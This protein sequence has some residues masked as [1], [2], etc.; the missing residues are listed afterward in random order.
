MAKIG[1]YYL[2]SLPGP[3]AETRVQGTADPNA[4]GAGVGQAMGNVGNAISSAGEAVFKNDLIQQEK[5]RKMN[6]LNAETN[7]ETEITNL[8]YGQEGLLHLQ[9]ENALPKVATK[10]TAAVPGVGQRVTDALAGIRKKYLDGFADDQEKMVFSQMFDDRAR[11]YTRAAM[12]HEV[13]QGDIAFQQS[14]EASR[15]S[16]ANLFATLAEKGD[17]PGA[18]TALNTGMGTFNSTGKTLGIPAE[19]L[20]QD[21]DAYA[22]STIA[23]TIIAQAKAKNIDLA[24]RM[25]DY[26]K[27]DLDVN[28]KALVEGELKPIIEQDE[29]L[30]FIET[31][32]KNDPSL[33]NPD[34]SINMDKALAKTTS[35][36]GPGVT[37][38]VNVPG[39]GQVSFEQLKG[40]VARNESGGNYDAHNDDSG[41]HGKYQFMPGTWS[42]IMSD[43]PMTPENQELAF[44]K[45]YKPIYDEYGAAGVLVAVYAGDSNAERY[46]KGENLIGD[47][48]QPYSADAPQ[49][50]YPSV[51]QY[52]I[53]ALGN[54]GLQGGATTQTVAAYDDPVR[55]AKLENL[56]RATV[57]DS[58]R[59][60]SQ[61]LGLE[62][63]RVKN[64]LAN[65]T[66]S[67]EQ[68]ETINS[69]SLPDSMKKDWSDKITAA[70]QSNLSKSANGALEVLKASGG[71]T[72]DAVQ[73]MKNQLG[74]TEYVSWLAKATS[75]QKTDAE[76][77]NDNA[78]TQWHSWVKS[79]LF[80]GK[81]NQ[82]NEYIADLKAFLDNE[83]ANGG[84]RTVKARQYIDNQKKD[85][86]YILGYRA[87]NAEGFNQ[88]DQFFP[89]DEGQTPISSLILKA[90]PN[91]DADGWVKMLNQFSSMVQEGDPDAT[92]AWNLIVDNGLPFTEETFWGIR[93]E[94]ARANNRI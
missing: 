51:R 20:K 10:D 88:I 4:F 58:V 49:G 27:N 80:P 75:Q 16:Y 35:L 1:Q 54:D 28:T 70:Y 71:L 87:R 57:S 50:E 33:R 82:Q 45:K 26:F 92:Y 69:S 48:G 55:F 40:L 9:G 2:D 22:S 65:V 46:I 85:V 39:R 3:I 63:D 76:K 81:A 43:A 17:F 93:N 38:T 64:A 24:N 19:A 31:E 66:T 36:R 74:F 25:F 52:V 68:L 42:G 72:V 5:R 12:Q 73:A 60:V 89:V 84:D 23:K 37:K 59:D 62:V 21:N 6:V 83:G 29:D 8:L 77:A 18:V 94:H 78:D 47:N 44:E 41:A 11:I 13:Q 32:I 15:T 67:Q 30:R 7:S 90:D 53:N 34:G 14:R 86:G 79:E 91:A 56:T 61:R